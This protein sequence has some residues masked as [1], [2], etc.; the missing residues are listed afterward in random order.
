MKLLELLES[1]TTVLPHIETSPA[2]NQSFEINFKDIAFVMNIRY[3]QA[4]DKTVATTSFH[5]KGAETSDKFGQTH[6]HAYSGAL[7]GTVLNILQKTQSHWDTLI[8]VSDGNRYGLY[9]ELGRKFAK[10]MYVYDFGD[11]TTGSVWVISK[12]PLTPEFQKIASQK[13]NDI[14][15]QKV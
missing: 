9:S 1:L 13:A 8:F 11:R 12:D 14:I 3:T 2:P 7:Y 5:E 4:D 10:N 15:T 6:K